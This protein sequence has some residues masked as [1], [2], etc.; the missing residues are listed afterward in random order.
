MSQF[1]APPSRTFHDLPKI[2]RM[3]MPE[4]T[5][6]MPQRG[7]TYLIVMPD[8][9]IAQDLELTIRDHDPQ[10][11]VIWC[12]TAAGAAAA[13]T[14]V[15]SLSIAFL[16]DQPRAFA[17]S[18]LASAIRERGGRVILLGEE[19]EAT[20]PTQDWSVL[21]RPFST[22]AVLAHLNA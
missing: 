22:A 12:K 21:H 16:A 17:K 6:V 1:N 9:L 13:L 5:T 20:G 8:V 11:C 19:A 15:A 7:Q 2:R 3:F 18:H 4:P 10:A 14:P